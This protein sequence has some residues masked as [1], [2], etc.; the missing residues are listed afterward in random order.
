MQTLIPKRIMKSRHG[1]CRIEANGVGKK[2]CPGV[3]LQ[4]DLARSTTEVQPP[5]D[6]IMG[7]MRI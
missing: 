6:L 7:G 2:Q 3:P 5:N 1:A 4:H